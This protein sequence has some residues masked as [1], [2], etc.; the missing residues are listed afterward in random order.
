MM[1]L[2]PI[3]EFYTDKTTRELPQCNGNPYT[4]KDHLYNKTASSVYIDG[5]VQERCNSIANALELHFSCT[6][7][8]ILNWDLIHVIIRIPDR[9]IIIIPPPPLHHPPCVS[10]MC[11]TPLLC[12]T[13]QV[14][15]LLGCYSLAEEQNLWTRIYRKIM[16]YVVFINCQ[17][18]KTFFVVIDYLLLGILLSS[19]W[20]EY[21]VL[22]MKG[23]Q[24][25]T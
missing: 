18:R 12:L 23:M 5:L 9:V 24:D 15:I 7:P 8:L 10:I 21:E 25:S 19:L 1:V 3:W 14:A 16:L 22:C 4:W 20:C 13:D 6:N 2:S 11:M 17:I